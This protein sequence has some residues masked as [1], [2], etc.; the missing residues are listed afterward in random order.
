MLKKNDQILKTFP[1]SH[2][3][4]PLTDS[5]DLTADP[6]LHYTKRFLTSGTVDMPFPQLETFLLPILL[7]PNQCLLDPTVQTIYNFHKV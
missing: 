3:T 2:V 4:W 1:K 5:P 6:L 7:S